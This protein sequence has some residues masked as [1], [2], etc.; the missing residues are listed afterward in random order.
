MRE[1][2][3]NSGLLDQIIVLGIKDS[4]SR[5]CPDYFPVDSFKY[6]LRLVDSIEITVRPNQINYAKTIEN[7]I[8]FGSCDLKKI[9]AF[10]LV[11]KVNRPVGVGNYFG[12]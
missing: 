1:K 5:T 2:L 10:D 3:P 11:I 9:I 4:F 12:A 8:E 7:F 6:A